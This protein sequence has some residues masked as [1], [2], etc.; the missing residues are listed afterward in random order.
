[1]TEA[2]NETAFRPV[3][4]L[5]LTRDEWRMAYAFGWCAYWTPAYGL[6]GL[7]EEDREELVGTVG[8]ILLWA[9]RNLHNRYGMKFQAVGVD[10]DGRVFLTKRDPIC[11]ENETYVKRFERGKGPHFG[12][13]LSF[14]LD[15]AREHLR[16]FDAE[17]MREMLARIVDDVKAIRAEMSP[18][19]EKLAEEGLDYWMKL[20]GLEKG[21]VR[22]RQMPEEVN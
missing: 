6:E 20:A 2:T 1:M 10:T 4:S 8:R 3:L 13:L 9:I 17:P 16:D 12:A 15:Y 22:R 21:A 11:L 19:E 5:W 18:E 14:A 7:A